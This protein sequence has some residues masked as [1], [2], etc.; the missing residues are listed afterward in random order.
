MG[1]LIYEGITDN[2]RT[3]LDLHIIPIFPVFILGPCTPPLSASR[4]HTRAHHHDSRELGSII[5]RRRVSRQSLP[6]EGEDRVREEFVRGSESFLLLLLLHPSL[7]ILARVTFSKYR[8]RTRRLPPP[9]RSSLLSRSTRP[10][11]HTVINQTVLKDGKKKGT[12]ASSF[13]VTNCS[14]VK[15]KGEGFPSSTTIVNH[16]MRLTR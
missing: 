9:S 1:G 15:R 6:A 12:V 14:L 11:R 13:L 10:R 8:L 3:R 7:Y 5:S 2:P 4:V 16:R